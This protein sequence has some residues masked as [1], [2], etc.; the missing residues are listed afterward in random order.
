MG[1]K[2]LEGTDRLF[3]FAAARGRLARFT[4]R[5]VLPVVAPIISLPLFQRRVVHFISQL[6][7]RYRNSPVSSETVYGSDG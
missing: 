2:L 7:V 6:Y 1:R 4:R 5:R 3:G